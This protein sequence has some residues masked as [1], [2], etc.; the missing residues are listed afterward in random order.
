MFLSNLSVSTWLRD[1]LAISTT[2][3]FLWSREN[4][5]AVCSKLHLI[6]ALEEVGRGSPIQPRYIRVTMTTAQSETMAWSRGCLDNKGLETM[7][8]VASPSKTVEVEVCST[9]PNRRKEERMALYWLKLIIH[10]KKAGWFSLGSYLKA[11]K[12]DRRVSDE[13]K[14][15]VINYL[16][17]LG[18]WSGHLKENALNA[19]IQRWREEDVMIIMKL[20][21][22]RSIVTN[23]DTKSF[24]NAL[25]IHRFK[26]VDRLINWNEL[27][28]V[29]LQVRR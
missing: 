26:Q 3:A 27:I 24:K 25:F 7:W 15:A 5:A 12:G 9:L 4:K 17:L 8:E 29:T 21:A 2:C 1:V 6:I 22:W 11:A 10:A 28:Q 16:H 13:R 23:Q 18:Y 14:S 20:Q 19:Y